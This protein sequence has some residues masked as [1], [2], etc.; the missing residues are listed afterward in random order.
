[1]LVAETVLPEG[2]AHTKIE[3]GDVLIK[4]NGE[5]LT[6]FVRLDDI[7]DSNV[8][9]KVIFTIQRGGEDMEAELVVGDLHAITP[10]RFVAVTGAAFHDLSYQQARLYAIPVKGVYVCDADGSFGFDKAEYGF[11]IQSIDHK[12]TPDLNTFIEVMKRIPG[13]SNGG[14]ERRSRLTSG[15]SKPSGCDLQTSG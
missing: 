15:R 10:D 1:M 4:V 6:R 5:P 8:G 13:L 12:K 14:K 2:P 9:Q 7:L 3:E 11:M